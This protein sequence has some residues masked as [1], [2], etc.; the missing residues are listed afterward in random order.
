MGD[1]ELFGCCLLKSGYRLA[2]DELLGFKHLTNGFQKLLL[3]RSILAFEVQHRNR[4]GALSGRAMGGQRL[5]HAI[6]LPVV[7]CGVT[8]GR[9][10]ASKKGRAEMAAKATREGIDRS[11]AF[12]YSDGSI[13]GSA[14]A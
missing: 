3:Q 12:L 10:G 6:I 2:Q 8:R 9:R 14:C 1:A 13:L 4:L 7:Q 5:L 11:F